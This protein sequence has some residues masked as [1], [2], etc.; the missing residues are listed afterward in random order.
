MLEL[1]NITYE[2]IENNVKKQILSNIN[3]VF[4]NDEIYVITGHNGS[5]KS[6]LVKIIMGIIMPTKGEIFYNGK[7]ITKL[8]ITERAK[9]GIGFSFQQPVTFKGLT[10]KNLLEVANNKITNVG[11]SCDYLSQVGMCAKNYVNR[12]L[13]GSLSGGEQKRIEIALTLSRNLQFNIFDEP[14]AGID[15]WSFDAL[16]NIFKKL[17][18]TVLI[19]S[20]QK[21][22]LNIANK[23]IVLN[24]GKVEAI[25]TK[26][27]I[28]PKTLNKTCLRLGDNNE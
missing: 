2:V 8:S 14:E 10:V 27:N 1:K 15:L 11:N 28:M 22:I 24:G 6:T 12:P 3:L 16:V 4:E 17:K 26:E 13:D 20:H 7:N 18:G 23:I 5:G 19:V 9:L 25:G 21:K